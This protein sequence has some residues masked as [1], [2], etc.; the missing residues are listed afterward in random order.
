MKL[1]IA[2]F[3]LVA[4]VATPAFAEDDEDSALKKAV[5]LKVIA[6][7]DDDSLVTKAVKLDAAADVV[8]DDDDS[9][10]KKAIK[11]K[12]LK[13]IGDAEEQAPNSNSRRDEPRR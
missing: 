9:T 11:L 12:A 5:Q 3:I 13:E 6:D 10:L 4:F 2:L 8:K 1:L 7:G